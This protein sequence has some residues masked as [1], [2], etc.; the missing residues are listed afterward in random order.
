MKCRKMTLKDAYELVRSKRPIIRPN[1]GFFLQL[2]CNLTLNYKKNRHC[3]TDIFYFQLMKPNYS[4]QIPF[5]WF[6]VKKPKLMF[7]T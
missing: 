5:S 1:V 2:H 4:T 3:F 7:Q 6:G